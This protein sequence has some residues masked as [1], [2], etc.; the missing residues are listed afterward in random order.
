[1]NIEALDH[2]GSIGGCDP[3]EFPREQFRKH[4]SVGPEPVAAI[5]LITGPDPAL[6]T[7]LP[8]RLRV[9]C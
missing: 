9:L 1:V 7:I 6:M 2:L 5:L 4:W 8:M 3:G